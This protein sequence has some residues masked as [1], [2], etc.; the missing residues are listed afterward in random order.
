MTP[1]LRYR[2]KVHTVLGTPLTFFSIAVGFVRK[3]NPRRQGEATGDF[4]NVAVT[5]SANMTPT[6]RYR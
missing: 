2:Q 6:L 5:G 4:E 3:Q 1:T